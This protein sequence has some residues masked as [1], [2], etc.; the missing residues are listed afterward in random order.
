MYLKS[1]DCFAQN[2]F[3][4]E[5][6]KDVDVDRRQ[7]QGKTH[8]NRGLDGKWKEPPVPW[9]LVA[10]DLA[11]P[12]NSNFYQMYRCSLIGSFHSRNPAHQCLIAF[13]LEER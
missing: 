11:G 1:L 5:S 9:S 13:T 10:A 6:D 4:N 8:G 2:Q 12:S 7:V 3:I